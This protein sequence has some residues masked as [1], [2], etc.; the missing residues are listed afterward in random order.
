MDNNFYGVITGDIVDSS[1][2]SDAALLLQALGEGFEIVKNLP[3]HTDSSFEI[4]RG[5]SFQG[6]L[7]P[8]A[9]LKASIIIRANLR[10]HQPESEQVYWDARTAIGIGTVDYL[11]E[12]ITEGDGE[13]FRLSGPNLDSMK[14]DHRLAIH[15]TWENL[16]EEL[17]TEAALLDAVIAKWRP[18]QAEIVLELLQQ[19][20]RK[21]ISERLDI[22][23]AAVHY[24]IKNAGWFAVQKLLKRFETVIGQ[25]TA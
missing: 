10:K 19:R 6:L 18:H 7:K 13:A 14:G 12:N 8:E 23:Q 24:R 17:S 22:S 9:A 20:E 5:D 3:G 15:T 11:P 2:A 4:F 21:E 25:K 1:K 16:N